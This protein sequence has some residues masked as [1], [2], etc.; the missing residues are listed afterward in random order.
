MKDAFVEGAIQALKCR[1]AGSCPVDA[2]QWIGI[3]RGLPQLATENLYAY[4]LRLQNAWTIWTYAGTKQGVLSAVQALGYSNVLIRE[5]YEWNAGYNPDPNGVVQWWRFWVI[6]DQPHSYAFSW[7][8]GDGSTWGSGKTWGLGQAQSIAD[9][10]SQIR[11]WKP[12][13]TIC[14]SLVIIISGKIWGGSNPVWKWS[15]G[16]V[17]GAKVAYANV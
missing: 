6:I 11:R 12:P 10:V 13:H 3:E 9:I 8:W 17:W 15:D 7:Y 2:L 1:W 5:N 16:T 4:R 14:S